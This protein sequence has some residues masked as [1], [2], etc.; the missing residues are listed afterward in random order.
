M[1]S[2]MRHELSVLIPVYNEACVGQVKRLL[3]LCQGVVDSG[4]PFS[5]EIIVSDDCSPDRSATEPNDAIAGLPCCRYIVQ[6]SNG[7]SAAN[8]NRLARESRYEWLLYVDCDVD[9]TSDLFI[10][11]YL[12]AEEADVIVGGL[13][14]GGNADLL[15]SNLRYLYERDSQEG[16]SAECRSQRA[17]Q[18]FRSCNFMVRRRVMLDCP[19]DERFLKSGYEDVLLGKQLR[20][21]RHT[22]SH[23]DNPVTMTRFEQN[24]DYMNKVEYS[25]QTLHRFRKDLRG[26]SR[27]LTTAEGIHL[28]VVQRTLA[29]LFRLLAPMVRRHLCGNRPRLYLFQPYRLG[30]Y[31]N[32]S[33]KHTKQ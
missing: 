26:Y 1:Q 8:R 21:G 4:H 20:A 9:L 6:P 29:M 24:P 18:S 23:I 7:G 33:L 27:L 30:Y 25:L 3:E 19:F 11:N 17:Y 22:I 31:L 10:Q 16:H 2:R 15:S 32:Y 5:F 12:T 14:V 28:Q 13:V